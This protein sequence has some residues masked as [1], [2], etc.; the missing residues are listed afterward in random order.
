MKSN[1]GEKFHPYKI[2]L[3]NK[4]QREELFNKIIEKHQVPDIWINNAGIAELSA[5]P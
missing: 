4:T 1:Y 3:T 5:L 2:D